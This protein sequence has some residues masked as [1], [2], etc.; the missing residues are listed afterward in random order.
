MGVVVDMISHLF[1]LLL[2]AYFLWNRNRDFWLQMHFLT[3]VVA[4]LLSMWCY[5]TYD[6]Y[7]MQYEIRESFVVLSAL[8]I[9]IELIQ[10]EK[11]KKKTII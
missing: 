5:K 1:A 3:V 4:T 6:F 2:F 7:N 10:K 9:F 8:L 11:V